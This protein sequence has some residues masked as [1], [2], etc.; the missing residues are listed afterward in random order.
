MRHFFRFFTNI[1]RDKPPKLPKPLKEKSVTLNS[2]IDKHDLELKLNQI[3]KFLLK[4]MMVSVCFEHKDIKKKRYLMGLAKKN[5]TPMTTQI[6]WKT[7]KQAY[8]N[9]V[10][11]SVKELQAIATTPHKLQDID[12]FTSTIK[13]HGR[14][15]E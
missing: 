14:A 4:G 12:S 6:G 2:K 3:K 15:K 13:L 11:D 10:L 5:K 1:L 7:D 9:I 8:K